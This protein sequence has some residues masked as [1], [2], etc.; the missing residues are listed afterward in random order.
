MNEWGFIG[1]PVGGII[2]IHS[3]NKMPGWKSTDTDQTKWQIHLKSDVISVWDSITIGMTRIQIENFGKT[4]KGFC[5]RK[6]DTFYSC[7][8]SNFSAVYLFQNDTLK[9]LTVTRKC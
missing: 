3:N 8:F 1:R 4:N 6:G 5:L 7:D 2:T 9:E